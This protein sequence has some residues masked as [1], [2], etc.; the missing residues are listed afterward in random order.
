MCT[1]P[2]H[3][4]LCPPLLVQLCTMG[5]RVLVKGFER[6]IMP[7]DSPFD[8]GVS[9]PSLPLPVCCKSPRF[10]SY[11][12]G[13][14]GISTCFYDTLPRRGGSFLVVTSTSPV[15]PFSSS[16]RRYLTTLRPDLSVPGE[17]LKLLQIVILCPPAQCGD[18]YTPS[19]LDAIYR[20]RY[21]PPCQGCVIYLVSG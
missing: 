12:A 8:F 14:S 3:S 11:I 18:S 13:S 17:L 21:R 16:Q 20:R 2:I 1:I 5:C 10:F 6:L 19:I 7:T 9:L 4:R 15:P